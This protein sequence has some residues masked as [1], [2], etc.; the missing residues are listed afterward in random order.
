[1][2]T[3]HAPDDGDYLNILD[4]LARRLDRKAAVILLLDELERQDKLTARGRAMRAQL[5]AG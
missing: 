3:L 5:M 4:D 2:A 1:N